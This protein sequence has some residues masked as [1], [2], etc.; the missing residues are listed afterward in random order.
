MMDA[1]ITCR[2]GSS[3]PM[4]PCRIRLCLVALIFGVTAGGCARSDQ[5]ATHE[6]IPVTVRVEFGPANK[7]SKEAELMVDRGSTPKDVVS[8]LFPIQSGEV[9][10]NTREI[11]SIDGVR[12]DPSRNRW[13]NCRLNGSTNVGAFRTELKPHDRVE[14]FYHEQSQ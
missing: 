1:L 3:A 4:F 12:P 5:F 8:I 10:C 2:L 13:W 6:R 14:W 7:P 11:A 9:C